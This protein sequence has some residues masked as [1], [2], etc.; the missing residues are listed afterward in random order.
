M[1]IIEKEEFTRNLVRNW[2][3][4]MSF[5]D[6]DV[7]DKCEYFTGGLYCVVGAGLTPD[8]LE[9]GVFDNGKAVR[10]LE[11]EGVRF[12]DT[13][14][15]HTIQSLYDN[16]EIDEVVSKVENYLGVS[17]EGVEGL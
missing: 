5:N 9:S 1:I 4:K 3:D 17:L 16:D 7:A 6:P 2:P 12:F 8:Q 13:D 15:L 14:F 10:L 11:K